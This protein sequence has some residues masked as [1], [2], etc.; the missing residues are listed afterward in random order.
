MTFESIAFL[1]GIITSCMQTII[2]TLATIYAL[3][4]LKESETTRRSQIGF[5]FVS[6]LNDAT[7]R[8]RRYEVYGRICRKKITKL[9]KKDEEILG[10]VANEFHSLGYM[11]NC[12]LVDKDLVLGLYY[13]T[14]ARL[15]KA[16][17]PWITIQ[18]EKRGTKYAE[19]FEYLAI[20]SEEYIELKRPTESPQLF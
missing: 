7:A 5:Y 17:V 8:K 20:L 10:L 12:E 14:V 18:R 9:S 4:Q 13:G 3:K 1:I 16:M 11:V 19:Y 2:M 6:R 15:W